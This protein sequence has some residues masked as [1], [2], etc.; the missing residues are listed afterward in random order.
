MLSN[1]K[2]AANLDCDEYSTILK[3]A[4]C[5][6]TEAAEASTESKQVE[7][8]KKAEKKPADVSSNAKDRY[9]PAD[10]STV[11]YGALSSNLPG[12]SDEK[13]YLSTAIAY[14]NGYPHVGHAYEV[15]FK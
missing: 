1:L 7:P 8:S 6:E 13:F 9:I 12:H 10:P 5:G 2:M 3:Y 11:K 15:L 4:T 14:T